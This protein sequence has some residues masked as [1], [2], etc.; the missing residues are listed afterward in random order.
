VA[1]KP[2]DGEAIQTARQEVAAA[3]QQVGCNDSN[4]MLS[5]PTITSERL[6]KGNDGSTAVW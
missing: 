6:A 5:L 4:F 1:A 2:E 3:L